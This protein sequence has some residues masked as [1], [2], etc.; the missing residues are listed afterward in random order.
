MPEA[1]FMAMS[2][3]IY[4]KLGLN[5]E[6]EYNNRKFEKA[7]ET[8]IL[9]N[10]YLPKRNGETTEVD[11]LCINKKGIFVF[12]S[13]NYSGWI[14]GNEKYKMWTQSLKGG[15]KY[16]FFNPIMQNKSHISAINNYLQNK[17]NDSF[18]SYIIFS[19]RCELKKISVYNKD[20]YVIN[21]YSLKKHLFITKQEMADRFSDA[22]IQDIYNQ[23]KIKTL[24]SDDV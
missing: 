15:K 13:K 17:Y 2:C 3:E 6:V 21:R 4:E 7:G 16:K 14:F 11:L 8:H 12:E 18:I 5:I 20:V 24:V 1:E 9:T 22:L 19:N 10:V 23:L